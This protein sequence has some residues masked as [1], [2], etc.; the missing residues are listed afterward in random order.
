MFS[1]LQSQLTDMNIVLDSHS[2]GLT[3]QQ[4][5]QETTALRERNENIQNQLE[6]SFGDRQTKTERN[7]ELEVQIDKEKNKINEM[8]F[9]LS[10]DDQQKYRQYLALSENLHQQNA[11]LH[12]KIE[13]VIRQKERLEA[14]VMTSQSRMEAARLLSKLNELVAKRNTLRDEEANRLS[15]AQERE[16]LINEVR[17]NNQALTSINRQMKIVSDQLNDKRDLLQQIEQDLDE[18]NSDRHA[19][20]KELKRRDETMSAFMDTFNLN[21][22]TEKQSKNKFLTIEK[23]NL[24][25]SFCRH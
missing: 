10:P 11:D 23:K 6:I 7:K 5:Q 14:T 19:K 1:D 15:P 21:M 4:I 22:Q 13:I 9:A 12:D 17:A 24:T 8:I 3:R 25:L 18:G 16:K 2:T 20:Y